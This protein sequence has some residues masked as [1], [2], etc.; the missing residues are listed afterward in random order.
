MPRYHALWDHDGDEHGQVRTLART[1]LSPDD[2]PAGKP[3]AL[4][5]TMRVPHVWVPSYAG[6]RRAGSSQGNPFDT[7]PDEAAAHAHGAASMPA[8]DTKPGPRKGGLEF[9]FDFDWLDST[10]TP[11]PAPTPAPT[12]MPTS[13][14][15]SA[16][17]APP[18]PASAASTAG[19]FGQQAPS[20]TS[21]DDDF[22]D[23]IALAG[24]AALDEN[25]HDYPSRQHATIGN[26]PAPSDGASTVISEESA[27]DSA[28]PLSA[29]AAEYERALL[30]ESQ[31]GPH[32]RNVAPAA[33]IERPPG[34]KPPADPFDDARLAPSSQSLLD[35]LVA[36]QNVD[37]ILESLDSFGAERLFEEDKP[38]EILAL[39][40]THRP[41]APSA[42]LAAR[43]A[44]EEHHLIS[45]DSQIDVLAAPSDEPPSPHENQ[46]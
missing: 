41:A 4:S 16:L 28:D 5:Y 15:D 19:D 35:L 37:T 27:E 40:A 31:A 30:H 1:L 13:T 32:T 3:A 18:P 8:F 20:A 26:R 9:D 29:L 45:M 10:P 46:R 14:A 38:H 25:Y 6:G 44:R 22:S 39:F 7:Q 36:G 12:P 11:T 17:R 43:L 21:A 23:L 33:T 34:A 2:R 24:S 42:S